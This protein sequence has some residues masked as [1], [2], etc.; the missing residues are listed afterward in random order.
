M[1]VCRG[2][3]KVLERKL[4][5][6]DILSRVCYEKAPL[7]SSRRDPLGH[8]EFRSTY[9]HLGESRWTNDPDTPCL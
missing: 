8:A 7:L 3:K 5:Y 2:L 6:K 1:N 9:H 4:A